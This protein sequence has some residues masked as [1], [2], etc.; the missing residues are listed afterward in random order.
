MKLV[1]IEWIDSH[2]GRGWNRVDELIDKCEPLLCRS[3]GWL[4]AET[5]DA[6]IIA[7]HL[8][9]EDNEGI[10][11]YASGDMTIP[12][13]AIRKMTILRGKAQ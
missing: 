5:K 1:L 4:V 6:K 10:H 9:G 13:K 8:S 11:I 7:P 2:S 3:V 12:T